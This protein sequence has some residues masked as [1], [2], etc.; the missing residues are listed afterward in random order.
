MVLSCGKV[1]EVSK[2]HVL[3]TLCEAHFTHHKSL[4]AGQWTQDLALILSSALVSG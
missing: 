4:E 3:S 1:K 2:N